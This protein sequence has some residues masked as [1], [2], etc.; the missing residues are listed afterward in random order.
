MFFFF[1]QAE[2]GIRDL[3]VT[4]VQRVLFRSMPVTIAAPTT[5]GSTPSALCL[6]AAPSA[7][8]ASTHSG[9][10]TASKCSDGDPESSTIG[11]S[12]L[13]PAEVN[14]AIR[15]VVEKNS[16][17]RQAWPILTGF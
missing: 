17:A 2:D 3:T 8:C 9:A 7:S 14:S 12:L 13:Q 10:A 6:A 16:C 15:T 1:F 11:V 4:G 5:C